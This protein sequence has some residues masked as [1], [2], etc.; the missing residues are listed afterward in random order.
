MRGAPACV[1]MRPNVPALKLVGRIPPV[2]GVEQVERLE[3]QLQPLRPDDGMSFESARST[4]QNDGPTARLRLASPR[5][6]G[7]AQREGGAVEVVVDLLTRFQVGGV[8]AWTIDVIADQVGPLNRGM[9]TDERAVDAAGDVEPAPR[10]RAEDARQPP[11]RRQRAHDPVA[12]LRRLVARVERP[13]VRA[14]LI[15]VAGVEIRV[16]RNRIAGAGLIEGRSAVAV[17]SHFDSV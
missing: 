11:V 8:L 6:P 14:V 16:V 4:C 9:R 7:A 12:N 15:A 13:Q 2:E 1:V 17:P 10:A 5:S 3:P